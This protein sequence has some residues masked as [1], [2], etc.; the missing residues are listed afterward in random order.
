MSSEQNQIIEV[1][2][3][4]DFSVLMVSQLYAKYEKNNANPEKNT[5]VR[6]K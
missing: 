2:K 5:V 1:Y 6:N 4:P 3:E